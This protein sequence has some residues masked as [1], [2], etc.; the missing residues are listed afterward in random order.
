MSN[1]LVVNDPQMPVP[2]TIVGGSGG[3]TPGGTNTQIQF[4]DSGAFG[5]AT[6]LAYNKAT[7][8]LEVSPG[9]QAA[10]GLSFFGS[11]NGIYYAGGGIGTFVG[12]SVSNVPNLIVTGSAGYGVIIPNI[13]QFQTGWDGGFSGPDV[14][15]QHSAAGV[16]EVNNGTK[17]TLADLKARNVTG[18]TLRLTN[19]PT[20]ATS[21]TSG[22]IWSNAGILTIVP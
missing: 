11:N 4:N 6:E 20:S 22:Q 21:L 14:A 17:G 1:V 2:I 5:G 15:L 3:A 9:S 16:L 8:Q 10:P 19:V 13:L 12:V 18:A 7:K